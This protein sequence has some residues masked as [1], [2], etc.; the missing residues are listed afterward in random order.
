MKYFH[1]FQQGPV[2]IEPNIIYDKRGFFFEKFKKDSLEEEIG[3]ELNFVQE[4]FAYSKS[5]VFRGMH[6]Q[7]NPFAQAKLISVTKGSVLDISIDIRKSSKNFGKYSIFELTE[8]N[9]LQLFIPRGFAH[10]YFATSSECVIQYKVDN[11]YNSNFE[12]GIKLDFQ[13][14]K[15]FFIGSLK[16]YEISDRD[17]SFPFLQDA[18]DLFD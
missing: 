14:I 9:H 6:Y 5:G 1:K 8:D 16:K 18:K 15:N 2:L 10:G 12:R 4:N 13:E 11:Y 17:N 7:L 3:Y